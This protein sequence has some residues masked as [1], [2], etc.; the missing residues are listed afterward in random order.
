MVKLTRRHLLKLFGAAPAAAAVAASMPVT[1]EPVITS[2]AIVPAENVN[3]I[4]ASGT[5]IA[6]HAEDYDMT[7]FT[8]DDYVLNVLRRPTPRA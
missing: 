4:L 6:M 8:I 7:N 2:H 3:K 1:A 5:S